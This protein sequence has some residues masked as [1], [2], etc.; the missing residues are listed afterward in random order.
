MPA[1]LPQPGEVTRLLDA[2]RSGDPEALDRLVPFVHAELRRIAARQLRRER[3]AHTLQPT[4]LVN[5]A[6]L[7]LVGQQ[8][9]WQNRAHFFGVAA[10]LMRRVLVDHARRRLTVRR[11]A[12]AVR[13]ELEEDTRVAPGPDLDLLA[14]DEALDALSLQ[15]ARQSK[16]VELRYFGGLSIEETAEALDVATSTV[17]LDWQMARSW[18]LRRLS[19]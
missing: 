2:W 8:A 11:G 3:G 15:D 13:I 7:R 5:E 9:R 19:T 17:K 6:F 10:K 18:L 4:A 14:L 16:V 1:S 12:G